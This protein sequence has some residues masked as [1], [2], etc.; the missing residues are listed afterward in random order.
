MESMWCND[1]H[2]YP[3]SSKSL[4]HAMSKCSHDPKCQMFYHWRGKG[5]SYYYCSYNVKAKMAKGTTSLGSVLYF[6]GKSV[7]TSNE[8]STDISI[9]GIPAL[10]IFI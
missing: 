4:L 3:A 6:K 1:Y 8:F 9:F 7:E 5:K 10:Y 2:K